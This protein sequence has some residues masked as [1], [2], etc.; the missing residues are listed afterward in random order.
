MMTKPLTYPFASGRG[1]AHTEILAG[2]R[3]GA[4][5]RPH[6]AGFLAAD[7]YR[8]YAGAELSHL[9]WAA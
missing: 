4:S 7:P 3:P 8:L 5:T 2:R 9:S 6:R 1:G